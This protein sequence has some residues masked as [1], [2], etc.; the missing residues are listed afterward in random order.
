MNPLLTKLF[1][2]SQ[3]VIDF[4][5]DHKSKFLRR[6]LIALPLVAWTAIF[7]QLNPLLIKFQVDSL[8]QNWTNLASVQLGSVFN[9]FL[10]IVGI[11]AFLN[12]LDGLFNYLQEYFVAKL[13]QEAE[14]F[15]EDKFTTFLTHFDGAFLSSENN[16]R[17]IRNLQWS[18]K[19]IENKFLTLIQKSVESVFGIAA[20][21]FVI[22]F[23]HPWL[24]GVI[25]VSVVVDLTLDFLQNQSWRQFELVE[26]RQSEQRNELKWRIIWYF[27]Q[28]LANNW[29]DKIFKIYTE[30]REKYFQTRFSQENIDRLYKFLK[31][32]S[33]AIVYSLATLIAGYLVLKN[34]IPIG[35]FVVFGLYIT[36]LKTQFES[37][38]SV[39]RNLFELRFDLFRLDFLLHIQPKLDYSNIQKFKDTQIQKIEV[40]NLDFHYP[41]FFIPIPLT[42]PTSTN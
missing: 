11:Y 16:L 14:S 41:E 8:T 33:Q 17:L 6:L 3:M 24:L 5:I 7:Y 37:I 18:L 36:R 34:E 4:V 1:G 31:A 32:S 12:L 2:V 30:R 9:V 42:T 13:N 38:A 26:S 27:N 22:P 35:T 15:L 23:I 20:L 19:D 28:V 40:K 10:V 39:F 25:A 21:I 29:M